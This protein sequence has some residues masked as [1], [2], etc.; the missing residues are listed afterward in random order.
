LDNCIVNTSDA[1]PR[2][3]NKKQETQI[4]RIRMVFIYSYKFHLLI[5][6]LALI[7][8][9]S[10]K[11]DASLQNEEKLDEIKQTLLSSNRCKVTININ[12]QVEKVG[13]GTSYEYPMDLG[14]GSHAA[15]GS[16][17][18]NTF[19]GSWNINYDGGAK[20]YT[21][22]VSVIIDLKYNDVKKVTWKE[23]YKSYVGNSLTFFSQY[24]FIGENIFLISNT[25]P[26]FQNSGEE[27]CQS[28]TEVSY[29]EHDY[30]NSTD[31]TLI[32]YSCG[33]TEYVR[34]LFW[35]E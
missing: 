25:T 8:L 3:A 20:N 11:E 13:S 9:L 18:D 10:C 30:E 5:I 35:E 7:S 32:S 34:I 17:T 21:G 2:Q 26:V 19:V 27:A 14:A 31:V 6:L 29:Y 33:E 24:S 23:D 1:P 15:T 28:L 22:T 12:A 4:I 16:F